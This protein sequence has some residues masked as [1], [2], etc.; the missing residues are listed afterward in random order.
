MQVMDMPCVKFRNSAKEYL[1]DLD[2][3]EY[4]VQRG[5][6][7]RAIGSIEAPCRF[8]KIL[9]LATRQEVMRAEQNSFPLGSTNNN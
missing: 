2:Q 7:C 8:D 6:S 9:F 4:L 3:F 5:I 1:E